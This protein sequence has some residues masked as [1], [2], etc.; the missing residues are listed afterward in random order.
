MIDLSNYQNFFSPFI[1]PDAPQYL[2]AAPFND[3][4]GLQVRYDIV[5]GHTIV[6]FRSAFDLSWAPPMLGE[7]DLVGVHHLT[8]GDFVLI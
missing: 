1:T 7:I 4:Q 2:G 5:G 8:A 6:Q 3:G